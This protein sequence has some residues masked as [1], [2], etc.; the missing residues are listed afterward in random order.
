M[1]GDLQDTPETIP[2]F[3]EQHAAGADVVYA[4]RQQRKENRLL[5]FFY[6]GFYRL[7][8][9]LAD[10]PLP[11]DAGDFGLM[12]RRV[13]AVLRASNERHRYLRGLR[14]WAGFRQ[15]GLPVE[16]GKRHAGSSKY[17][18]RKLLKLAFDG[19]FAFSVMPLR[20]ATLIGGFAIV[21]SFLF[22]GYCLFAKLVLQ[23]SLAGFT[24]LYVSMTFLAGVQLL[25]LGVIG[26][27][28][29]RT[30]EEVKRRP[31]YVVDQTL[32]GDTKSTLSTTDQR[33][34]SVPNGTISQRGPQTVLVG[35]HE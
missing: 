12:S 7:I 30:Y 16:R 27:Y 22:A 31:L 8:T 3:L 6:S 23:Q 11:M 28:V 4:V 10:I 5:R 1:D 17:G 14:T 21:A 26:E 15:V 2:R 18:L 35:K 19:I 13:V 32:R 34:G 20:F 9:A 29:G 33:S 25:F 24:A